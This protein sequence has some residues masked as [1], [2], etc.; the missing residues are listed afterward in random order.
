MKSIG[1][2]GEV[3]AAA[4]RREDGCAQRRVCE[5]RRVAGRG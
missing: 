5:M 3:I 1:S 2:K 4:V